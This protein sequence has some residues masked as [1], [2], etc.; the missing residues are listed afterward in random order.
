L[1]A[2]YLSQPKQIR[3]AFRNRLESEDKSDGRKRTVM[4]WRNDLKEIRSL[5]ENWDE[6][7]APPINSQ[8]IAHVTAFVLSLDKHIANGVRLF[9]TRLGA[10]MLKFETEHGRIKCEIG[11]KQMSYFVKRPNCQTEHHSF[12]DIN[13]DTLSVLKSNLEKI[14]L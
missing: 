10:V 3:K 8:V 4:Q 2:F 6:E 5:K 11:D 9:P 13:S 1:W 14:A 7:Q 12:V